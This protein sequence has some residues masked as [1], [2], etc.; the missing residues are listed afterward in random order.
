MEDSFSL[1]LGLTESS[2]LIRKNAESVN[3]PRKRAAIRKNRYGL[4]LD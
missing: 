4:L 1:F 2:G 3:M